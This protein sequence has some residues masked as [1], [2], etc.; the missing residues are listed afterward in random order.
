MEGVINTNMRE[1]GR[2]LIRRK[3]QNMD[4]VHK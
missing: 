2:M 1:G 3:Y 4:I